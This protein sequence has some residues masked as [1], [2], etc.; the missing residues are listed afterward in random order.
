M[1]FPNV[2]F[3]L[4][5]FDANEA[6]HRAHFPFVGDALTPTVACRPVDGCNLAIAQS[7][8]V[9]IRRQSEQSGTSVTSNRPYDFPHEQFLPRRKRRGSENA[10]HRTLRPLARDGFIDLGQDERDGRRRPIKLTKT[11]KDKVVHATEPAPMKNSRISSGTINWS[12]CAGPCATS[13]KARSF[14]MLFSRPK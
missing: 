12:S 14:L 4:A 8:F 6:I 3:N 2:P 11:G 13:P 10:S 1:R 7:S 9:E 5:G